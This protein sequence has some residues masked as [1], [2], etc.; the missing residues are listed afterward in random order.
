MPRYI[1]RQYLAEARYFAECFKISKDCKTFLYR[2]GL[3][4]IFFGRGPKNFY[5][6]LK[7]KNH[8]IVY[9]YFC[10]FLIPR[11]S[12]VSILSTKL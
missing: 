8:F 11:Y 4:F 6:K 5:V 9:T 12:A 10:N 7:K 2:Y 1:N 3:H